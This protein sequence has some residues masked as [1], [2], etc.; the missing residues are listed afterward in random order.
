MIK[1]WANRVKIDLMIISNFY[2]FSHLYSDMVDSA[3]YCFGFGL[4]GLG[5]G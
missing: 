3:A 4:V 5:T 2:Q 1:N